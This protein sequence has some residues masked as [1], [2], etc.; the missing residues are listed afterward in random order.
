MRLISPRLISLI[1]LDKSICVQQSA[2]ERRFVEA[3]VSDE[4]KDEPVEFY[5]GM[6]MPKRFQSGDMSRGTQTFWIVAAILAVGLVILYFQ[7]RLPD[8]HPYK[9]CETLFGQDTHCAGS[10]AAE[11]IMRRSY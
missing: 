9:Q 10:I 7:T 8:G 6:E 1:L 2:T 11:R 3:A 4:K 5:E